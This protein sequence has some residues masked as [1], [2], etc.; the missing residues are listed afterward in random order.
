MTPANTTT[1]SNVFAGVILCGAHHA[2]MNEIAA[3]VFWPG[4][5]E[6][7]EYAT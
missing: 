2:P 3:K 4:A 6:L 5:R 7:L 1:A